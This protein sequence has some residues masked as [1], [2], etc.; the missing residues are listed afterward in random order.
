[1]MTDQADSTQSYTWHND[2]E[3]YFA[4]FLLKSHMMTDQ[5]D[6]TQSYTWHDDLEDYFV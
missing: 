3:H 5:A 2:F 1:M 4:G 6:S